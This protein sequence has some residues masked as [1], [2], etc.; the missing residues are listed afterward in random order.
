MKDKPVRTIKYQ[1]PDAKHFNKMCKK[2][3]PSSPPS[4]WGVERI[5]QNEILATFVKKT[6][7]FL[8]SWLRKRRKKVRKIGMS[9]LRKKIK[10]S[11]S[12]PKRYFYPILDSLTLPLVVSRKPHGRPRMFKMAAA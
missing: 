7:N 12:S 1:S 3:N 9:F 8:T 4:P 6:D 11:K 2:N 5:L 10:S